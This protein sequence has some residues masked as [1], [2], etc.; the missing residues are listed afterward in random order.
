MAQP[1]FR[2][3]PSPNGALH[4]GHAL[5]AL[6]NQEFAER[7]GGRLLVRIEDIDPTR[8]RPHLIAPM[9]ADLAWLGLNWER[10]E[11]RQSH[12]LGDYQT[13]LQR[14]ATDGL[15]F[16]CYASRNEVQAAAIERRLGTD[17]DGA[18]LYAGQGNIIS[19]IEATHRAQA[20]APFTMRLNMHRALERISRP[21]M[22][23]QL[24]PDGSISERPADPGRWGDV[25][26][27][28]KDVRTSYHLSVVVDDALQAITHVVR[29]ND[30]DA[31][32]DVHRLLQ[33]LLA[34]PSPV[35]HHHRLILADDGRK[36]AKSRGDTSLA[37]L[38]KAG[39]SPDAIRSLVGL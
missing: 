39:A 17:P 22:I 38:R 34:L 11:R 29:G 37:S 31:A 26:L 32:T 35:Y 13:A 4:L 33:H 36:L 30:L 19:A 28:R 12:H 14:L 21:L 7:M 24:A 5:S 10:P 27:G 9:L 2:F 1:V 25:V 15:I 8:C 18:L 6:L 3:A 23:Q 20:D 16:P